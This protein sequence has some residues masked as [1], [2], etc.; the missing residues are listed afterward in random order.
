MGCNCK[1]KINKKYTDGKDDGRE[2][3][4][5][6]G[7]FFYKILNVFFYL[8]VVVFSFAL[9]PVAII[10]V[11]TKGFKGEKAEIKTPFIDKIKKMKKDE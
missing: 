1:S 2:N 5:A 3:R 9:L 8:L 4:S 7:V 6:V 10:F 11:I